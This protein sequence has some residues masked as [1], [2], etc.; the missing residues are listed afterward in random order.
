[1]I[2]L[3]LWAVDSIEFDRSWSEVE[4]DEYVFT[5][6]WVH[7]ETLGAHFYRMDVQFDNSSRN[8]I[9]AA[10]DFETDYNDEYFDGGFWCKVCFVADEVVER[11]IGKIQ[12][13]VVEEYT[14]IDIF[15]EKQFGERKAWNVML[16]FHDGYAEGDGVRVEYPKL[17]ELTAE[18]INAIDRYCG[19]RITDSKCVIPYDVCLKYGKVVHFGIINGKDGHDKEL[20]RKINLLWMNDKIRFHQILVAL[21]SR[22]LQEIMDADSFAE[23]PD[24]PGKAC[25]ELENNWDKYAANYMQHIA[26]D[27]D[28]ETIINFIRS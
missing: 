10:S 12:R 28:L 20:V 6:L 9:G 14:D 27:L 2:I 3:C 13:K 11:V 18:Q 21:Y 15:D 1:M 26:D 24:S 17:D 23:L 8:D 4:S 16:N 22:D 7:R 5:E 19:G 25:I